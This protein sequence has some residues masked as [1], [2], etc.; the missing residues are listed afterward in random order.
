MYDPRQSGL[1]KTNKVGCTP[2]LSFFILWPSQIRLAGFYLSDGAPSKKKMDGASIVAGFILTG[3]VGSILAWAMLS[4][5]HVPRHHVEEWICTI[6]RFG[7][8]IKGQGAH[9]RLRWLWVQR[10][11]VFNG[12][13]TTHIPSEFTIEMP[14]LH[15]VNED[16][17]Y[18]FSVET[19]CTFKVSRMEALFGGSDLYKDCEDQIRDVLEEHAVMSANTRGQS[20]RVAEYCKSKIALIYPKDIKLTRFSMSISPSPET[21]ADLRRQ[22]RFNPESDQ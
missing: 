19:T 10:S 1:I 2:P 20:N 13:E 18:G 22:W 9:I 5:S 3:L 6:P 4:I 15:R 17:G 7:R 21:A 11:L 14:T 12:K 16:D 8:R